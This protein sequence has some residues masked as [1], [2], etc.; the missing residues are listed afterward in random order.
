[1]DVIKFV[2]FLLVGIYLIV[3]TYD[4]SLN[5]MNPYFYLHNN[6]FMW[7]CNNG[8]RD[9]SVTANVPASDSVFN[10]LV[11]AR[12]SQFLC[13]I[14]GLSRDTSGWNLFALVWVGLVL[15]LKIHVFSFRVIL[16]IDICPPPPC[17]TAMSI[18]H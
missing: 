11:D 3:H 1:M 12:L 18:S 2:Y 9:I 6:I 15:R 4:I 16:Q 7:S 13:H 8:R 10:S 5:I 17:H 14:C